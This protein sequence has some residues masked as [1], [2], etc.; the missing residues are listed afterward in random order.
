MGEMNT[1]I[2]NE[3]LKYVIGRY[4]HYFDSVNN[5]GNLYLSINTFILGGVIAGYFSLEKTYH[6]GVGIL[7]IFV[8]T[9]T[10]N[11]IAIVLTLLAIKPHFKSLA[12]H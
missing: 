9:L 12:Y 4:D 7:A 10:A 5:K 1:Q 8:F 6:F 11:M 3:E 2:K